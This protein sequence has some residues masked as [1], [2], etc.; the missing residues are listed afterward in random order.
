MKRSAMERS[1]QR[2]DKIRDGILERLQ[3][4]HGAESVML[5]SEEIANRRCPTLPSGSLLFDKALGGGWPF[6]R[7]VEVYGPAGGGKTTIS[8]RAIAEVQA[9]SENNIAAFIDAEHTFDPLYAKA[10]GVQVEDLLISQPDNGEQGLQMV[11]DMIQAGVNIIVVDSVAELRPAAEF[12]TELSAADRLGAHAKMLTKAL[13]RLIPSAGKAGCLVIMLN[14]IR[15]NVTGYGN[16]ETTTGG[17]AF[18]H[19]ASIRVE[20]RAGEKLKHGEDDIYGQKVRLN[21]VKN[22]LAPPHRRVECD[23]IFGRGLWT[24]GEILDLAVEH[25]IVQKSGVWYQYGEQR[26]GQGRENAARYIEQ[27]PSQ[28]TTSEGAETNTK[29]GSVPLLQEIEN[30]VRAKLFAR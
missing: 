30:H 8:L 27:N 20:V 17:K 16:P 10:I 7:I 15:A 5:M 25:G 28:V 6:G 29:V 26:L 24:A 13:H 1:G 14:Q 2:A 18:L 3:K 23:L 4:K 22:K 11:E 19:L 21:I 12:E 9:K